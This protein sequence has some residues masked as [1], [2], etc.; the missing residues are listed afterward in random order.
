M[1]K[2]RIGINGFGRI[3]RCLLRSLLDRDDIEVG[4]INDL[5]DADDLAYLLQYDSVHGK[6]NKTV[7]AEGGNIVVGDTKIPVTAERNPADLKWGDLGVD[8]V[9]ESTGVFTKREKAALHMEGG[10]KRVIISAPSKDSDGM[11]VLGVNGNKYDPAKHQV[12]SM[13]SCTTNCLA[14]V[15]KVLNDRF[16]V[17]KLLITTVHAYTATQSILD[18]PS[19]NRRRGRAAALNIIP[20]STGAA[21]A[22]TKVLPELEGK[23]DGMALRVPVPDGSVTDIVATLN[24]DVSVESVNQA[25]IEASKTPELDGIMGVSDDHIVSGDIVGDP[26]SSIV[27]LTTTQVLGNRMVKVLSWYDNETG[28]ATRLGDFALHMA[29]QGV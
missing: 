21:I 2:L 11:F 14:P 15:A 28:Y 9:V 25:M 3:G 22:V 29:K 5:T 1:S 20:S 18:I 16:G 8:V 10:A 24:Q 17:D 23:M 27:D 7:T 12:I 4:G 26:R 6:L 13:A 19:G